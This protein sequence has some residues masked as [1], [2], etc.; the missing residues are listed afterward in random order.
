MEQVSKIFCKTLI[1]ERIKIMKKY[2]FAIMIFFITPFL[3]AEDKLD[4]STKQ[5]LTLDEQEVFNSVKRMF[6]QHC[7]ECVIDTYWDKLE[8]IQYAT[9]GYLDIDIIATHLVL[10]YDN[11][12]QNYTLEIFEKVEEN[13]Y[14]LST[15]DSLYDV[16]WNRIEYSF[17]ITTS[18]VEC[19]FIAWAYMRH[20]LCRI[21]KEF[22][23]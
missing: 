1:K 11:T 2:L 12:T 22:F 14:P 13:T 7:K 23:P 3:V 10:S 17:G 20:P 18:W 15:N 21:D 19:S 6:R 8:I 16:L 9:K 5:F 4:I